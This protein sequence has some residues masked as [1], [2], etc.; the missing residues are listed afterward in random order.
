MKKFS[1]KR[2]EQFALRLVFWELT[3]A[4]NLKCIHCRASASPGRSPEELTTEEGKKLID[5]IVEFARPIL[6]FSGGEPLY[7]ADVF[8]LARH[9]SLRGLPI[10]LATNGT[11]I[12]M[13][14]AREIK[15]SGFRRVSISIDGSNARTHD[16]FRGISGSF[17]RAIEGF[18]NLKEI[19]MSLQFNTTIA[20]HNVDELPEILRLAENLGADALHLFLLVPVGCGVEIADEQMING[21]RYEEVLAWLCDMMTETKMELKATCAPHFYRILRQKK[22]KFGRERKDGMSAITKGCLA[23][24]SVCFVSHRGNIYPC[25]Y[26]PV[27]AGNVRTQSLGEIWKN[28]QVFASLRDTSLLK[29]KCGICEFRN[30]CEGCRARAFYSKGDYLEEE[31]FCIYEPGM[32]KKD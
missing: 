10:A 5:S 30:V 17:E 7:R 4:C 24:T 8:D 6:I 22:V 21:E 18:M 26:L 11:L 32:G 20:N 9:A 3:P 12:D 14:S 27:G 25:G 29:G 23:G 31:P 28:S 1:A 16:S 2:E 19:G 15:E 13:K